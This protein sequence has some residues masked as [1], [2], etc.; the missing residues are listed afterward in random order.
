MYLY[1]NKCINILKQNIN[2]NCKKSLKHKPI[3]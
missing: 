2:L 3:I 1:F